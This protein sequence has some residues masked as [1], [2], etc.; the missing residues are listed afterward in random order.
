MQV[1]ILYYFF[2][3][4]EDI[5]KTIMTAVCCEFNQHNGIHKGFADVY[6]KEKQ[7]RNNTL[8]SLP[9]TLFFWGHPMSTKHALNLHSPLSFL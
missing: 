7:M 1:I 2:K 8:L 6:K 3:D 5:F 9:I 4:T